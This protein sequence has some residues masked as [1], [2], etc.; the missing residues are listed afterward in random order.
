MT[1]ES[2]AIPY[3]PALLRAERLLVL[4]PHPDDEVIG[5]GGLVAS[6]LREQRQVR[7]VVATDG[8]EAGDAVRRQAESRRG[9]EILGGA[10]IEFLGFPD[11]AL[12]AQR[13]ACGGR[14]AAVL[15]DWKPDLVLVPSPVEFH[16]DHL[17]L[18]VAFCELVQRDPTLFAELGATRVAFYEVGQPLRPNAIVD[19]TTVAELKYT[20]IAAHESQ[21]AFRD[22]GAYTRGLN[23]FRAMTMPP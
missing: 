14:L 10:P 16:P 4:A 3:E 22:Y 6:H 21:L 12:D 7:I 15:R 20:A 23:A 9:V 5:C 17:A 18:S 13:D 2:D 11:R 8:A 1:S 19:I